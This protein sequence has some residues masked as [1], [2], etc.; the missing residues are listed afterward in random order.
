MSEA[1]TTPATEVTDQVT[2]PEGSEAK[3]LESQTATKDTPKTP[4][5]MSEKFLALA[6]K[7]K[8]VVKARQEIS[9]M[10]AEFEK[11]QA[12]FK[13]QMQEFQRWKQLKDNAKLD[14]DAYLQEAG[15][16]YGSLTERNLQGGID[17][18][19]ILEKTNQTI[20]QF[21]KEQEEKEKA[22]Q[23]AAKTQAQKDYEARVGQFV[24]GIYDFV[25][26]NQDTYE[27]TNQTGQQNL[28]WEVIQAA[29]KRGT[30]MTVK[31][32]AEKVEEYL[33]EQAEKV[34]S[35]K[36]FQGKYTKVVKEEEAPKVTPAPTLTNNI[37]ASS[38]PKPGMLTEQQR[39]QNALAVL[40]K[41]DT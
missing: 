14:P 7:E 34:L 22:A 20:A 30:D 11:Q 33:S 9:A 12:Q 15:L 2:Q 36:K 6:R 18:K 13:E 29:A 17:P 25:E 31:Q 23:E 37:T 19:A 8:S 24:Q 41:F 3:S 1:T 26:Q 32:A 5:F 16:S 28:I 35:S 21:K 4:E 40:N 39:I 27:L 38:Q 10:K